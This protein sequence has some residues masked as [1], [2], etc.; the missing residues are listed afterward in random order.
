MLNALAIVL[1]VV[2]GG[3]LFARRAESA[4]TPLATG[5]PPT[6]AAP[7][8]ASAPAIAAAEPADAGAG[9]GGPPE[10]IDLAIAPDGGVPHHPKGTSYRSPF[11]KPDAPVPLRVDVAM[12]L[13]SVDDYDVKTGKFA[14][15]FYLSLTS[16]EPMPDLDL[17]VANG[18]IDKKSVVADRPTFKLYRITGQF[19]SPADLRKYPFDAQ[20]LRIVIEDDKRGTDQ[21]RLV[22]DK[23]RTT[24][25]RGFRA[26]GWQVSYVEA[27][28]LS[29]VHGDRF[30]GDDLYYGRYVFT[31]GL[32]RF[33]TSA[34]FK[35]FVPAFVIVLISLLG[36]WVPP[37]E[38]EVR[39]NAGAPMLA[40]AVLFH[41]TLMQELPATSYFTRADKLMLGVY[42]SLV[43]GMVST[44][45][46]F[47]VP[48]DHIRRV[49]RIARVVVPC[50]TILVM[51][52]AC[53]LLPA[54]ETASV[55]TQ[56]G[57]LGDEGLAAL[58]VAV[59]TD[60]GAGH[61]QIRADLDALVVGFVL[62]IRL[63]RAVADPHDVA[64]V[65]VAVRHV[66][67]DDVDRDLAADLEP[68]PA[69]GE[70][71]VAADQLA[72]VAGAI[73]VAQL[74]VHHARRAR[75]TTE[76]VDARELD[77]RA[78]RPLPP[79]TREERRCDQRE[80]GERQDSR[81]SRH[82]F[83]LSAVPRKNEPTRESPRPPAAGATDSEIASSCPA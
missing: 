28:S 77:G 39:S 26:V 42:V 2:F 48:E 80:R 64:A 44:W 3:Y 75:I 29:V 38:M 25:A 33:A 24:L 6:P 49:F 74:D 23:E 78:V 58:A 63:D 15:D 12:M 35:V 59:H 27:R 21:V 41:Y 40:G 60:D 62:R 61:L 8:I 66:G 17:Q 7:A 52:L 55:A 54:D 45:W 51:A 72:G 31:L 34:T 5:T 9:D 82:A 13:N 14:A 70:L 83:F 50:I 79:A 57:A 43:L 1:T 81:V 30:E 73:H 56:P 46:M 4:P 20:D 47:I 32:E 71:L 19:K 18:A 68:Q 69:R 11:A 36:M 53:T 16:V 76:G 10:P 65:D 67:R 37:E 22:V